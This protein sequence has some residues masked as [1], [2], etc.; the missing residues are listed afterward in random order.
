MKMRTERLWAYFDERAALSAVTMPI[1]EH[2]VTAVIGP[3]GCG[4]TTFLRTL[5]RMHEVNPNARID[6]AVFLDAQNVYSASVHAPSIRKRVG[7]VFQKPNPFPN[8]SIRDNVLAGLRLNRLAVDDPAFQVERALT[9]A[10][11]WSEVKDLLDS[12]ATRLTRGQQQRMCIARCLALDPEVVLMDDPCSQLDP[13]ATA[14]MEELFHELKQNYT[15]VVVTHNLQQAA[16]VS[17]FTAF[18]HGGELVEFDLADVV[19]TRPTETRTEDY[20]TGRFG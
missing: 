12:D 13:V 4:K 5:N 17:D 9:S 18:L 3:S 15:L 1:Y 14:R 19:F 6:G 16:R 10:D 2:A 11:L 20:I 8:M 7:M